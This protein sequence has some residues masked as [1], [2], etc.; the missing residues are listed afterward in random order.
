ML[1]VVD[2]R[3]SAGDTGR[4][5]SDS[6]Q[7]VADGESAD[8]VVLRRPMENNRVRTQTL[9]DLVRESRLRHDFGSSFLYST[10]LVTIDITHRKFTIASDIVVIPKVT[11]GTDASFPH[12][13]SSKSS[14]SI[15][16]PSSNELV[17]T[18]VQ[19]AYEG[20][21]AAADVNAISAEINDG[22]SG[23][24]LAIT[25]TDLHIQMTIDAGVHNVNDVIGLIAGDVG[26]SALVVGTV[27][28]GSTGTNACD[29]FDAT[30]W[31]S[32]SDRFLRGGVPGISHKI[33]P[34]GLATFFATAAN[35]ME[36][37]DTIAIEYDQLVSLT[38]TG[39]RLQSTTENTNT[40]VSTALFNARRYPAKVP[41]CIPLCKRIDSSTIQFANGAMF[42]W[43][44]PGYLY[45]DSIALLGAA[46]GYVE[47]SSWSRMDTG[48]VHNPA[49]TIQ[50]A[51][52]NADGHIDQ[53]LDWGEATD[54]L[55]SGVYTSLGAKLNRHAGHAGVGGQKVSVGASA[56]DYCM[57]TGAA[58]L[59]QAVTDLNASGGGTILIKPGTYS[60]TAANKLPQISAS[61]KIIGI[62]QP[63]LKNELGTS[64]GWMLDFDASDCVVENIR[65]EADASTASNE[66]VNTASTASRIGFRNCY[67][68]GWSQIRGQYIAARDCQLEDSANTT[69][70]NKL[71]VLSVSGTQTH[72]VFLENV[73]V[74]AKRT[75]TTFAAVE[76]EPTV[77]SEVG[78]THYALGG[79]KGM[80][81]DA[82]EG[83]RG[84]YSDGGTAYVE[85][86]TI[87][88][89]PYTAGFPVFYL[90]SSGYAS[91]VKNLAI[92]PEDRT[93]EQIYATLIHIAQDF[94]EVEHVVLSNAMQ[95]VALGSYT[96]GNNP[97]IVTGSDAK[98]R[99]LRAVFFVPDTGNYTTTLDYQQ[100]IFKLEGSLHRPACL[101]DSFIYI[102]AHPAYTGNVTFSVFGTAG[103]IGSAGWTPMAVRDTLVDFSAIPNRPRTADTSYVIHNPGHGTFIE[104]CTF[105]DQTTRDPANNIIVFLAYVYTSSDFTMKDCM[106]EFASSTFRGALQAYHSSGGDAYRITFEGNTLYLGEIATGSG[107]RYF[108][109]IAGSGRS[110]HH[111]ILNNRFNVVSP[112]NMNQG[113]YLGDIEESTCIGNIMNLGLAVAEIQYNNQASCIPVTNPSDLNILT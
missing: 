79:I 25:V 39:G 89:R 14:L 64:G 29:V 17:L 50:E 31:T 65:I 51:L 54:P 8:Q 69:G 84:F 102:F 85:D 93:A 106:V 81:I 24:S 94:A 45:W 110:F 97:V 58:G 26:A 43:I 104:R 5:N 77:Y 15:G 101:E 44:M 56:G 95:G 10:G 76:F 1:H 36:L 48:T 59:K 68:Q 100:P 46:T 53:I 113:M 112:T 66:A 21:S 6:I 13:V 80:T 111:R 107:G 75:T 18:S 60:I 38:T 70:T 2:F 41:N 49:D 61:I 105:R 40:D 11:T 109:I 12:L 35:E 57:Y 4:A 37:G 87:M 88:C 16:T 72:H 32:V 73:F 67:F 27:G 52:D 92:E 55:N 83:L 22:G 91:K 42:N 9:R 86:L 3:T 62:G 7:P 96:S 71:Y 28:S 90:G 33:T 63:I 34:A 30:T 103:G 78:N 23:A 82:R 108:E 19:K 98:L 74:S 20:S 47:T 99:K